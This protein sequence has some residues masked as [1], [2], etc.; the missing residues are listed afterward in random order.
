ME[1]REK[2]CCSCKSGVGWVEVCEKNCS[3]VRG[4]SLEGERNM[5]CVL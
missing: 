5:K 2:H 3:L 4:N 1:R